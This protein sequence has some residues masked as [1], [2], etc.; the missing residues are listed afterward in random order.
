MCEWLSLGGKA[1]TLKDKIKIKMD[2]LYERVQEIL[3]MRRRMKRVAIDIY[4]DKMQLY[5][6]SGRMS[7]KDRRYSDRNSGKK[8]NPTGSS[9]FSPLDVRKGYR[10]HPSFSQRTRLSISS[11][12]SMISALNLFMSS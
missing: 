4:P 12:A 2:A 9:T 5:S 1:A 6:A 10:A 7:K 11:N 3:D 8:G